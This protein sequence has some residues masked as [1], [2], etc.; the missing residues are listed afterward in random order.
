[1][2]V[3]GQHEV[4]GVLRTDVDLSYLGYGILLFRYFEAQGAVWTA[5]SL[6]KSPVNR[7]ER[8]FFSR[9]QPTLL[10]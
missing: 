10:E 7:H 3:L 1:M 8:T 5:V 4:I 6:V 9:C 2:L